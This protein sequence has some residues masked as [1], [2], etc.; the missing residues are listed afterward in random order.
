MILEQEA[1]WLWNELA[2]PTEGIAGQEDD[3]ELIVR[4]GLLGAAMIGRGGASSLVARPYRPEDFAALREVAAFLE[5]WAAALRRLAEG[6]EG[7]KPRKTN[8][9][10]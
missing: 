4:L 1:L 10:G 7:E 5:E 3:R 8:L 6:K 2:W 9:G